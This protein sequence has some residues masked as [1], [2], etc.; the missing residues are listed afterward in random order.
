MALMRAT[1]SWALTAEQTARRGY[2][3]AARSELALRN[4]MEELLRQRFPDAR[5]CHEMVM[6]E[7]E[8]RADIVAIDTGHIV[9]V[10]V[11]GSADTTVRLLHQV[12]MYQLCVPEVWMVLDHRHA[13]DG[14]MLRHLLP[15]IGLITA[16]NSMAGYGGGMSGDGTF[17][18]EVVAEPL[19]RPP[20]PEMMLQMM[21]AQELAN[22][23]NTTRVAT[24]GSAKP[25]RAKMIRLLL[26]KIEPS[27]LLKA[28]CAE[29]RN[30]H[31]LW[32]ADPPIGDG[33]PASNCA[34]TYLLP[35]G[36]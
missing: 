14:A 22:M 11:K 6:G 28:C 16:H 20:H 10:E 5:I 29:L 1:E 13:G 36:Q 7:R 3:V 17:R 27:D 30:R 35:E 25:R 2:G 33:A 18:L 32:R 19:P 4:G 24:I 26:D 15:S 21:W 31:A 9:A 8:V 23:C 34:K 12:G